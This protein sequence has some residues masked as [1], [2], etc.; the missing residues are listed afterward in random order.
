[1][2]FVQT[3]SGFS[4]F[5]SF[6]PIVAYDCSWLIFIAVQYINTQ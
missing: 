3:D 5:M 1:M 2:K 6:S 4:S